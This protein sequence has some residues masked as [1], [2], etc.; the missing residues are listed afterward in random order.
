MKTLTIL[1]FINII[2]FTL[3]LTSSI[4]LYKKSTTITYFIATTWTIF[5]LMNICFQL[6]LKEPKKYFVIF[7]VILMILYTILTHRYVLNGKEIK[8]KNDTNIIITIIA[9]MWLFLAFIFKKIATISIFEEE[10]GNNMSIESSI[11]HNINLQEIYKNL[12][13]ERSQLLDKATLH[14]IKNI[15]LSDSTSKIA[16]DI[17]ELNI[18]N[19]YYTIDPHTDTTDY[20]KYIISEFKPLASTDKNM[21]NLLINLRT[22]YDRGGQRGA[23]LLSTA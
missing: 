8:N 7:L 2:L 23:S 18:K 5:L 3:L 19:I 21:N 13:T 14:Y 12:V 15:I 6:V 20:I 4:R 16:K 1:Y 22:I 11:K 10:D 17:I 9:C